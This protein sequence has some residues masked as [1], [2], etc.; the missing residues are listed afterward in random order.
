MLNQRIDFVRFCFLISENGFYTLYFVLAQNIEKVPE[1]KLINYSE[2]NP[3]SPWTQSYQQSTMKAHVGS[4]CFFLLYRVAQNEPTSSHYLHL[5]CMILTLPEK[6]S[7]QIN[8]WGRQLYWFLLKKAMRTCKLISVVSKIWAIKSHF[9]GH[10]VIMTHVIAIWSNRGIS[11]QPS[12]S[13]GPTG[14]SCEGVWGGDEIEL[15][16]GCL[17]N[18]G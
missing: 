2:L 10:T 3:K 8:V 4:E 17:G 18:V 6:I 1:I 7:K 14:R 9:L 13:L 11:Y 16:G 15:L 5:I 12:A